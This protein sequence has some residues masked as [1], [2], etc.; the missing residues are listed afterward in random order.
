MIV[1]TKT[2]SENT[3]TVWSL[4]LARQN[5]ARV[6]IATLRYGTSETRHV[7]SVLI[8]LVVF[9]AQVPTG[10]QFYFPSLS[11]LFAECPTGVDKDRA[12]PIP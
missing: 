5:S 12:R 9:A 2:H 4:F 11:N 7:K 1:T 6:V 3:E 8:P 10:E